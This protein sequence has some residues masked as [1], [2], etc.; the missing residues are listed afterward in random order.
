MVCEDAVHI[1]SEVGVTLFEEVVLLVAK[2][3][4]EKGES[5]LLFI[6]ISHCDVL[7]KV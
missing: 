6:H 2:S 1:T 4:A 7:I 3:G 5:V